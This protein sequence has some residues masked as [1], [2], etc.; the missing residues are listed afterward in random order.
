MSLLWMLQHLC[1]SFMPV[2]VCASACVCVSCLRVEM[3][4]CQTCVYMCVQI[5]ASLH[6]AH[7]GTSHARGPNIKALLFLIRSPSGFNRISGKKRAAPHPQMS[8]SRHWYLSH[9]NASVCTPWRITFIYAKGKS[10]SS[11]TNLSVAFPK[12]ALTTRD[13]R[14]RGG[15]GIPSKPNHCVYF[16]VFA[17]R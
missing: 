11:H 15:K 6:A 8:W 5:P 1:T 14:E 10:I 17:I 7:K 3:R 9:L 16:K 12:H 13:F 4:V 2:A